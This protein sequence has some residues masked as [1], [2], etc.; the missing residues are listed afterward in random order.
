M[1]YVWQ[2]FSAIEVGYHVE[3][4][5][6]Q[7]EQL[8]EQNRQLAAVGGAVERPGPDRPDRKAAWTE[9]ASAGA[10]GAAG[11]LGMR[12][13]PVLAQAQKPSFGTIQ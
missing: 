13:A 11:W 6:Q 8:R 4:Q 3:A 2:H 9:R 7:V 5:K 12:T 1:V 10:G